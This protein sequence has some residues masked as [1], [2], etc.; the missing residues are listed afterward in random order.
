M[1]LDENEA[2]NFMNLFLKPE[3]ERHL[4]AI[5]MCKSQIKLYTNYCYVA[6]I[7]YESSIKGHLQD[8][9][10]TQKTIDSLKHK[11]GWT[12]GERK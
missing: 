6:K 11:F 12:N 7:A 4:N 1:K 9:E 10:E 8:V 3:I 2:T 5:K